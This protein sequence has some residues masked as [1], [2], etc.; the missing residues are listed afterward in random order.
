MRFYSREEGDSAWAPIAIVLTV[1]LVVMC[2]G[3]FAWYAPSQTQANSPTVNVN[4]P[5]T[6]PPP[7]TVVVPSPGTQGAAGP[8]G[9]SGPAGAP[10]A[11]G[12]NGADGATGATG[13]TGKPGEPGEPTPA[14]PPSGGK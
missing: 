13:A 10:G 7:T 9:N 12:A 5:S 11:N 2:I 6:S 14:N 1:V 8:S 4:T 3:Y